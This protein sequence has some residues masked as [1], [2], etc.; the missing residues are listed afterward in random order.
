[1]RSRRSAGAPGRA[2]SCHRRHSGCQ[3]AYSKNYVPR[4]EVVDYAWDNHHDELRF[5]FD[6][7]RAEGWFEAGGSGSNC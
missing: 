3:G 7:E 6:G 4:D 1:V 5:S 2:T